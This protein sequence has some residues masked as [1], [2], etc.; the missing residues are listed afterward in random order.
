MEKRME[1]VADL[2]LGEDEDVDKFSDD[3]FVKGDV[4]N[5]SYVSKEEFKNNT[6]NT[7]KLMLGEQ[8]FEDTEVSSIVTEPSSE[9]VSAFVD[10]LDTKEDGKLDKEE[11]GDCIRELM[12][13][14]L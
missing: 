8:L 3:E 2:L 10:S 4:D 12:R 13:Q 6:L 14:I 7:I 5:D 1:Y 11:F 9:D